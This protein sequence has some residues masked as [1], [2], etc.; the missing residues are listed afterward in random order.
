MSEETRVEL[1]VLN[2]IGAYEVAAVGALM[3]DQVAKRLRSIARTNARAGTQTFIAREGGTW[4]V[5]ARS[6]STLSKIYRDDPH[7]GFYELRATFPETAKGSPD[8]RR[9]PDLELVPVDA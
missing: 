7:D 5:A 1:G 2:A 9:T 8:T 4:G 6:L 3:P